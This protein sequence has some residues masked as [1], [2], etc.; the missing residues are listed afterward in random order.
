M[1]V[2]TSG[3][4]SSLH[5]THI[6]I[7][8]IMIFIA[9]YSAYKIPLISIVNKSKNDILILKKKTAIKT[10]AKRK[11]K[12]KISR[13]ISN[14]FHSLGNS[15]HLKTEFPHSNRH[16]IIPF[17]PPSG[18]DGWSLLRWRRRQLLCGSP[19]REI[20]KHWSEWNHIP[21]GFGW[22]QGECWIARE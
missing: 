18:F 5:S 13:R 6:F 2:F 15:F 22:S 10:F 4:R 21:T 7:Y 11:N 9:L 3:G 16:F 8:T 14:Q 17:S 12:A 1:E 19:M 20:L